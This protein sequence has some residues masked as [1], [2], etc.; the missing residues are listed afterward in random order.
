MIKGL[1]KLPSH[2][3][4]GLK[5][6]AVFPCRFSFH[7]QPKFPRGFPP[8]T[9]KIPGDSPQNPRDFARWVFSSSSSIFLLVSE[10]PQNFQHLL[11]VLCLFINLSSGKTGFGRLSG[12][13]YYNRGSLPSTVS[14]YVDFKPTFTL[15]R[16]SAIQ[17]K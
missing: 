3:S 14:Q 9:T 2:F 5:I 11:L 15:Y 4:A 1:G 13:F 7:L 16:L 12:G 6:S 8:P 17:V 10:F